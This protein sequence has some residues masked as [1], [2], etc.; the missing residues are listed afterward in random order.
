MVTKTLFKGPISEVVFSSSLSSD[1]CGLV[2]FTLAPEHMP[3][4]YFLP[5]LNPTLCE[6]GLLHPLSSSTDVMQR[7]RYLRNTR[8][9]KHRKGHITFSLYETIESG[10]KILRILH[11]CLFPSHKSLMFILLKPKRTKQSFLTFINMSLKPS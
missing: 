10:P 11:G 3:V 4:S 1:F 8:L 5:S 6:G 2:A 9:I 7:R